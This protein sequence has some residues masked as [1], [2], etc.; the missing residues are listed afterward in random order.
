MKSML[1]TWVWEAK[2]ILALKTQQVV[3]STQA[4]LTLPWLVSHLQLKRAQMP[5]HSNLLSSKIIPLS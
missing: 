2:I 3:M 4:K 1:M 5:T